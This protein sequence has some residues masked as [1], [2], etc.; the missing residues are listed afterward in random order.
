[1]YDKENV[2]QKAQALECT[3]ELVTK[4]ADLGYGEYRT[5]LALADQVAASYGWNNGA[6]NKFNRLLKDSLDP[7]GILAPGRSGIWPAKYRG[8]GFELLGGETRSDQNVRSQAE[9]VEALSGLEIKGNCHT[10]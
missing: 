4:C 2:A 10:K 1:M 3:R 9:V 5:H 7:N 6:I 8:R